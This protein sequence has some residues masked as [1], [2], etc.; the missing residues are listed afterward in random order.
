MT[1]ISQYPEITSPDV[2]DLLIGTDVENS[3]ATKNF[4]VQSVIDLV[5]IPTLQQ[6]SESGNDIVVDA[7]VAEGVNITLSN[8]STVYQNGVIV[9]VPAQTGDYPQYQPAPDAFIA[10]LNG[11]NPG[12]LVGN[13]VGFVS[14]MSGADNYGFIA[15]L[16]ANASNSSGYLSRSYDTHTG[17]LYEGI[18][19]TSGTP[20]EVFKVD[21]DG[22]ITAKSFVK[23][24]GTSS[25]YLMANGT[26]STTPTLQQITDAGATT[27]DTVTINK[28]EGDQALIITGN[29]VGD[30]LLQ[31]T[32]IDGLCIK[33]SGVDGETVLI[34]NTNGTAIRATS[35][36]GTGIVGSSIDGTGIT[37]ITTGQGG[38]ALSVG[39]AARGITVSNGGMLIQ[40][41]AHDDTGYQLSLSANSAAK[42]TSNMWTIASDERVKTNINL[43][44]KGLETILA[45]NPITY[46]YN[47]KAGFDTTNTGNIGIIAQDVLNVIPESI[48]T[49]YAKLNEEDEEKTELYNFDSH[50][51]TF[52]LINAVKQLSAEVELLKAR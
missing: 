33:A 7:D 23:T 40:G 39:G 21:N 37:A 2:D 5:P 20:S 24:G 41:I 3:N 47:G 22:D 1:K 48:K 26:T 43:Y 8:N 51:L 15:Q 32:T 34:N 30:G 12:T 31:I 42:P 27:N 13:P 52:I 11:Q 38:T 35:E 14:D 10:Y 29:D 28:A 44:T 45:I 46:D 50:A 17:N 4:T 6:V 36:E 25:Q 16:N 18:K 49:F 19:I 9:T